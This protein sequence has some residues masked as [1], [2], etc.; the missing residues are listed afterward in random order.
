M[1]PTPRAWRSLVLGATWA[2]QYNLDTLIPRHGPVS[3]FQ[4]CCGCCQTI[5][6]SDTAESAYNLCGVHYPD[7]PAFFAPLLARNRTGCTEVRISR[8]TRSAWLHY[9]HPCLPRRGR[10]AGDSASGARPRRSAQGI[11][12]VPPKRPACMRCAKRRRRPSVRRQCPPVAGEPASLPVRQQVVVETSPA[13]EHVW[14]HAA[15]RRAVRPALE[16]TQQPDR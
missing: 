10:L 5:V 1:P 16:H 15:G 7:L 11:Y 13:A 6:P 2:R 9:P 8:C 4:N 14:R 3:A 12:P